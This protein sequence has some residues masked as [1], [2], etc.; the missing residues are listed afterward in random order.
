VGTVLVVDDQ[1][2]ACR[3]LARLLR[4]FGHDASCTDSGP[5]ALAY[6]SSNKPDLVILDVMMPGMDGLDVLRVILFSALSDPKFRDYAINEG[7]NDY[8]I[9]GAIDFSKLD[10]HLA[11]YLPPN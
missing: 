2:D 3:A 11:Q 4:H 10:Q 9:K 6:L 8:W 7:A 1:M 5:N